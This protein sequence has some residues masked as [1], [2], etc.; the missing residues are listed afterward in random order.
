MLKR[1]MKRIRDLWTGKVMIFLCVACLPLSL[2]FLV[3]WDICFLLLGLIL[4]PLYTNWKT[5]I[6][7]KGLLVP[8]YQLQSIRLCVWVLK[9]MKFSLFK[10]Y[11]IYILLVF[12]VLLV[13]LGIYGKYVLNSY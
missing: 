7:R 3:V 6:K 8:L 4:F 9:K 13:I 12:L 11:W 10:G 2:L 5:L 1:Q